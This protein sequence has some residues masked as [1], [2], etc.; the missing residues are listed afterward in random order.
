MFFCL[1]CLCH[2]LIPNTVFLGNYGRQVWMLLGM[3]H[4]FTYKLKRVKIQKKGYILQFYQIFRCCEVRG[5]SL[6]GNTEIVL[7]LRHGVFSVTAVTSPTHSKF[8]FLII[9]RDL[10]HENLNMSLHL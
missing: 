3:W 7:T 10:C 1:K 8:S 5:F 2:T 9:K 4:V 6:T